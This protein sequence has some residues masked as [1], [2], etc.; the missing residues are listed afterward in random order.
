MKDTI[1]LSAGITCMAL[2]TSIAVFV[3]GKFLF[4]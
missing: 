2:S 4:C 1:L 3:L